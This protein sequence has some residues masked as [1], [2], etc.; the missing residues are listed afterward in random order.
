[1][2]SKFYTFYQNN[3]GGSFDINF[4]DGIGKYVIVEAIN[5]DNANDIAE[6]IGIYFDGCITGND[7]DCCGDRWY[8]VSDNDANLNPM[9]YNDGV[10][11]Y[12]EKKKDRP[13]AIHY[14]DGKVEKFNFK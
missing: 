2:E 9:I 5:S 14:L 11:F 1:M 10:Y 12:I 7:C 4:N 13:I 6:K 3:S 8:R